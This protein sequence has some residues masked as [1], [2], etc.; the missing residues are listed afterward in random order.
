MAIFLTADSTVIVQ[1]MTGSEGMKH[2][3][4][5]LR[6]GTSIVGGV[7]PRK[8]G[9]TVD[10]EGGTTVPVYGT[11]AEAVDAT[12]A[13]VT[14]IFVPAQFTKAA[15]VE[16]VDAGIPLAVVITE[17]VA[18]KDTAEVYNYAK[19]RGTTRSAGPTCPVRTSPGERTGGITPADICGPGRNDARVARAGA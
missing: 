3:Q 1:G 2:T 4:R 15:V 10:F 18:V 19:D 14:V 13:D 12:G 16:A 8:A 11:V 7:N 9:T 5:M 6:S 17:G